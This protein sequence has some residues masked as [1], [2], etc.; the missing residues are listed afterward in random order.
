MFVFGNCTTRIRAAVPRMCFI[1]EYAAEG[2][3][4]VIIYLVST[5]KAF[6]LPQCIGGIPQT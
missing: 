1:Q 5:N 4:D 6:T 2:A 3:S